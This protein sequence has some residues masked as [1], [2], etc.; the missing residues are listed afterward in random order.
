MCLH[1]LKTRLIIL[2]LSLLPAL[3]VAQK[4]GLVLSGGGA[5]GMAHI[6]AIRALEE[7]GIPI[8]CITG[9][10]A[11]AL[12]GG[13]YAAGYSPDQIYRL[14]LEQG[15]SWLAPGLS[16]EEEFYYKKGDPDGTFINVPINF[17]EEGLKPPS[18]LISDAEININLAKHL[19]HASAIANNDFDSLF[20]P[21]RCVTADILERRTIIMEE[22]SLPFA[23]R[24]SMAV[25]VFFP[26]A[27]HEEHPNLFDGGIYDN[28]PVG[29]MEDIFEPDIILGIDVTLGRSDADA[30][31]RYET[32][33]FRQVISHNIDS[34][35]WRKMP[36]TGIFIAP[37]LGGMSSMDFQPSKLLFA[38]EQGY[39]ATMACMEDIKKVI[40]R[41]IPADSMDAQRERFRKH[42]PIVIG[43]IKINDE[44]KRTEQIFVRNLMGIQPG[45]TITPAQL[46]EAY[47]RLRGVGNYMGTFPELLWDEARG[48]YTLRL[49]LKKSTRLELNLGG[50]FFTPT[51]HQLELKAALHTN[52]ILGFKGEVDLVRGSYLNHLGGGGSIY[53]PTKRPLMLEVDAGITQRDYQLNTF[54]VFARE[55]RAGVNNETYYLRPRISLPLKGRSRL[56]L[57][58]ARMYLQDWYYLEPTFNDNDEPDQTTFLGNQINLEYARSSLNKKVYPTEGGLVEFRANYNW[59]DEDFNPRNPKNLRPT[60]SHTWGQTHLRLQRYLTLSANLRTGLGLTSAFSTLTP[61]A[62]DTASLLYS[63]K[64]QPLSDSPILFLPQLYSKLFV[65]LSNQ[66][67]YRLS[68]RIFAR[69]ELHYMQ[70]FSELERDA[71]GEVQQVFDFTWQNRAIAGMAGIIYDSRVG[72]IGAFAHYYENGDNSFRFL[73]HIG[74]MI[75]RRHPLH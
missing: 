68:K 60:G 46:R 69:M 36:N 10:S 57:G 42:P 27:K 1:N 9:T 16:V 6:G 45:D 43:E 75:F 14:L 58:Y 63:P 49:Y 4:V 59:G 55:N 32:N 25:P 52:Q 39:R 22:G 62:T 11:G 2:L 26:P 47:T 70:D 38:V 35:S 31:K 18:S 48:N 17:R 67:S 7:N 53:F 23:I 44:I 33:F 19:S 50:A 40:E 71:E 13:F 37:D 3:G 51:D 54:N 72:P 34:E 74:Y 66:W 61:M 5:L 12:V 29:P 21:F 20:V 65:G 30:R 73:M 8:D 15:N 41:R 64:F 56:M 28:F 24:G